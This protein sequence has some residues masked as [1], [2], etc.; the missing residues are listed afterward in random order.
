MPSRTLEP[1]FS[2]NK[3]S[4]SRL[5]RRRIE[6]FYLTAPVDFAALIAFMQGRHVEFFFRQDRFAGMMLQL[7][8]HIF[9]IVRN[10]ENDFNRRVHL[11]RKAGDRS[12]NHHAPNVDWTNGDSFSWGFCLFTKMLNH[13]RIE[14]MI[15]N[16]TTMP[17]KIVSPASI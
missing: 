15:I 7:V 6:F 11:A 3:N 12:H 8:L 16:R 14:I 4:T 17:K 2:K 13:K 5:I 9:G 1:P 10:I